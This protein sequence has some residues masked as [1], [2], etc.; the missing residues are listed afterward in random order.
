MSK[1]C[2]SLGMGGGAASGAG[3]GG[4]LDEAGR[5]WTK[6]SGNMPRAPL[7]VPSHH[8]SSACVRE[9]EVQGVR[10]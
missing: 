9:M 6:L 4:L 1:L 7:S 2:C 10:V 3:A 5:T 8:P